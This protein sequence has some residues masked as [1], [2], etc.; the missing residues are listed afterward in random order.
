MARGGL[1]WGPLQRYRDLSVDA[2]MV[3]ASRDSTSTVRRV[4]LDGR[5]PTGSGSGEAA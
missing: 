1:D 3:S 4:G 5:E 2:A